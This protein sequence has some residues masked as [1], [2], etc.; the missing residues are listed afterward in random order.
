MEN[1][2]PIQKHIIDAIDTEGF[3]VP[4]CNTVQEKLQ[5]LADRFKSEYGWSIERKGYLNSMVDW[6]QGLAINIEYQNHIIIQMGYLFGDI[7]ADATEAHEDRYINQWFSKLALTTLNL[8][9]KY[10]INY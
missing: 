10:K 5:F 8:F 2:T 9:E 6:L 4:V 1:L 7:Q 3:N